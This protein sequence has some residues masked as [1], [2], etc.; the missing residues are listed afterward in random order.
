MD[1]HLSGLLSQHQRKRTIIVKGGSDKGKAV[2][3]LWNLLIGYIIPHSKRGGKP[4]KYYA[5]TIKRTM[6]EQKAVTVFH[7]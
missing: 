7:M 2:E 6:D 1:I 3:K 4:K 5:Y